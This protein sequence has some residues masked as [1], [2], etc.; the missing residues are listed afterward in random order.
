M[1][2]GGDFGSQ[3]SSF[4]CVPREVTALPQLNLESLAG[5]MESDFDGLQAD[6]ERL[7][8]LGVREAFDF[9]QHEDG[10]I[11][12]LKR[13]DVLIQ[14]V[15]HFLSEYAMLRVWRPV[16]GRRALLI[17]GHSEMRANERAPESIKRAIRRDPVH[18][19]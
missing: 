5:A 11:A 9:A 12:G 8:D 3:I 7:S 4:S 6:A 18:P 13:L 1:D 17:E 19:R 14:A 10:P 16:C 2:T 15:A